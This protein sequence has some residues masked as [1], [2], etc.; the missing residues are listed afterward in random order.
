MAHKV[1]HPPEIEVKRIYQEV[2]DEFYAWE[3]DYCRQTLRGLA[4]TPK[5]QNVIPEHSDAQTIISSVPTTSLDPDCTRV[6]IFSLDGDFQTENQSCPTYVFPTMEAIKP[7]EACTFSHK[8]LYIADED[9][10]KIPFVPF[11][12]NPRFPVGEYMNIY[13]DIG[14]ETQKDPDCK[15]SDFMTLFI[16]DGDLVEV[17][18]AEAAR[19]LHFAHS[20][21]FQDIDDTGMLPVPIMERPG[22]KGLLQIFT[23]RYVNT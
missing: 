6:T 4:K 22:K 11:A 1:A 20:M 13:E 14:W 3:Q 15:L 16:S 18:S 2:W 5:R 12:D 19:R 8:N 10:E 9:C 7:Y 23:Q 21:S 17:I